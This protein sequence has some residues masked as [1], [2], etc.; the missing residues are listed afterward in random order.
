MPQRNRTFLLR[1]AEERSR[2]REAATV[3]TTIRGATAAAYTSVAVLAGHFA[4]TRFSPQYAAVNFRFKTFWG[5][6]AVVAA[7]AIA[8][9]RQHALNLRISREIEAEKMEA[10]DRA[11][12]AALKE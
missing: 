10:H 4:A 6:A 1:C 12:L 9:E 7:Y 3:S 11:R 5:G 8:G 2:I